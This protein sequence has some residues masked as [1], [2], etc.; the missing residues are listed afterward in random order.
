[1]SAGRSFHSVSGLWFWYDCAVGDRAGVLALLRD[2]G[3]RE[4]GRLTMEEAFMG[5]SLFGD[6]EEPRSGS[7]RRTSHAE[8][9]RS[10]R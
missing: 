6:I 7:R 5:L 4:A 10:L 9:G 2:G 3:G 8:S 1:M